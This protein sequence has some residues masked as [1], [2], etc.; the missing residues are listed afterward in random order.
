MTREDYVQHA[1]DKACVSEG[2]T[3]ALCHLARDFENLEPLTAALRHFN[4]S[5]QILDDIVDV[6]EDQKAGHWNYFG[7]LLNDFLVRE[8]IDADETPGNLL[9][10][11]FYYLSGAP[12]EGYRWALWHLDQVRVCLAGGRLSHALG[13]CVESQSNYCR[14]RCRQIEAAVSDAF[15]LAPAPAL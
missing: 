9:L 8:N 12:A 13:K 6:W 1:I 5:L 3:L 10:R 11:K 2:I 15:R 7:E 14:K 4:V